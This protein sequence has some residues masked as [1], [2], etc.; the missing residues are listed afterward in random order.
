MVDLKGDYE[1]DGFVTG[2]E[3]IPPH[4]VSYYTEK[5]KAFIENYQVTQIC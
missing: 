1:K 3:V 4:R 2:I 5:Y